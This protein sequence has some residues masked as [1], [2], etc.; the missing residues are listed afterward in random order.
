M[1]TWTKFPVY[2][3]IKDKRLIARRHSN[4]PPT[5]RTGD[6]EWRP[7]QQIQ[8]KVGCSAIITWAIT[9]DGVRQITT[10]S[11][12]LAIEDEDSHDS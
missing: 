10:T 12:G 4:S 7:Y 6:G 2:E 3:V 5:E 1:L 11:I 8:A 9:P